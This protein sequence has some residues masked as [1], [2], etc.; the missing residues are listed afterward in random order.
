MW[1]LDSGSN[2]CAIERHGIEQN[3]AGG[4]QSWA[5]VVL[6]TFGWDNC[7][8]RTGLVG[9]SLFVGVPVFT[10][11]TMACGRVADIPLPARVFIWSRKARGG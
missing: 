7:W 9:A 3:E 10:R 4:G 8:S 2:R 6:T 11:L 1:A 5:R